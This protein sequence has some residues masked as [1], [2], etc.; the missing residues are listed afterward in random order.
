MC[1][2]ANWNAQ[3]INWCQKWSVANKWI[4]DVWMNESTPAIKIE[5]G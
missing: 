4:M 5:I 3:R 2:A 1:I